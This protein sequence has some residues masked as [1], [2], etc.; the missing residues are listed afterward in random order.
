MSVRARCPCSRICDVK[1]VISVSDSEADKVQGTA[2]E[3]VDSEQ[4]FA[5]VYDE[6]RR[7]AAS[8]LAGER[9][10]HTLQPTAL[11]HEAYLRL[12]E[13]SG[14]SWENRRHFF[15]AAA[16]AMRRILVEAARQKGRLKRGGKAQRQHL[17]IV[18]I[19][20]L[21]RPARLVELDDALR[22]LE[23]RHPQAGNW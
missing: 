17:D 8:K 16:E 5:L 4:L 7:L 23:S 13:V 21:E 6:L 1:L 15:G 3:T 9:S 11:V 2:R 20:S 18:L 22:L 19:A 10:D 14:G 12:V